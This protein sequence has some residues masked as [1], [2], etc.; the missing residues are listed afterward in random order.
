VTLSLSLSLS[1]SLCVHT[2]TCELRDCGPSIYFYWRSRE[3]CSVCGLQESA[4]VSHQMMFYAL[5]F[6]FLLSFFLSLPELSILNFE[7]AAA[8]V[9]DIGS[10]GTSWWYILCIQR[11]TRVIPKG[12]ETE[13]FFTKIQYMWTQDPLRWSWST[14]FQELKIKNHVFWI[15]FD[16]P[17]SRL[18]LSG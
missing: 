10:N 14:L 13:S 7:T 17:S 18:K 1:L 6:A 12:F 4:R 9:G 15:I 8:Q 3:Y 16:H 2:H 5:C 11:E